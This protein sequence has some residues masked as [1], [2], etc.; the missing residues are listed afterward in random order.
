MIVS[1]ELSILI[2]NSLT[3]PI[4]RVFLYFLIQTISIWKK[5]ILL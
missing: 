4:R 3:N 1:E 5:Y 2:Q